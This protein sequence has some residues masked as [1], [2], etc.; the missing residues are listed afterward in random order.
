MGRALK[1]PVPRSSM[2][3]MLGQHS[4]REAIEEIEE[5]LEPQKPSSIAKTTKVI[6]EAVAEPLEEAVIPKISN[7]QPVIVQARPTPVI[8]SPRERV[9]EPVLSHTRITKTK[10]RD[11]S[12]TETTSDIV[13]ALVR[14]CSEATGSSVSASHILRATL[15]ALSEALPEIE[16]EFQKLG[17]LKRPGNEQRFEAQRLEYERIIAAAIKNGLCLNR[18]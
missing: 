18:H 6:V 16:K 15:Y 1:K 2:S 14:S 5:E 17:A 8:E 10:T 12:L 13:D 7:A 4:A 11:F 9:E 3:R